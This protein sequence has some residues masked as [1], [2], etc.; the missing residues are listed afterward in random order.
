MTIGDRET[1]SMEQVVKLS[2]ILFYFL[3]QWYIW[4]SYGNAL[5]RK[6]LARKPEAPVGI[7]TR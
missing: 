6:N 3:R 2:F 7:R 4:D 1:V 5:V